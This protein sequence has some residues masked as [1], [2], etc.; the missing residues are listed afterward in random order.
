MCPKR[1]NHNVQKKHFKQMKN[2]FYLQRTEG[3]PLFQVEKMHDFIPRK[4]LEA[5]VQVLNTKT[6][7]Q[8]RQRTKLLLLIKT[9]FVSLN[10]QISTFVTHNIKHLEEMMPSQDPFLHWSCGELWLCQSGREK[11]VWFLD[12]SISHSDLNVIC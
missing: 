11:S 7:I 2:V 6:I 3:V 8:K 4:T 5:L 12:H 9:D 1:L 10:Q